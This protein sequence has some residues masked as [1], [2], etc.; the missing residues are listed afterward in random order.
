MSF[1][2]FERWRRHLFDDMLEFKHCEVWQCL[3]LGSMG[4]WDFVDVDP[5][6]WGAVFHATS[7]AVGLGVARWWTGTVGVIHD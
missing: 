2:L 7:E 6:F 1:D 4:F 3:G 5:G